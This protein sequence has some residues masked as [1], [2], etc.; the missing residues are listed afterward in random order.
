MSNEVSDIEFQE[1]LAKIRAHQHDLIDKHGNYVQQ[2]FGGEDQ[3]TP[4][5]FYSV[6]A[7]QHGLPDVLISGALPAEIAM[8]LINDTLQNWRDHGLKIGIRS[9]A[10]KDY[11]FNLSINI[12][13][14]EVNVELTDTWVVQAECFYENN[15]SYMKREAHVP[16]YVQILLPDPQGKLPHEEGFKSEQMPQTFLKTK[17]TH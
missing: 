4:P 2:V 14:L 15:P 17:T 1:R 11:N 12:V 13:E 3:T 16:A 7:A 5:F 8:H 6:G 9:E 10:D